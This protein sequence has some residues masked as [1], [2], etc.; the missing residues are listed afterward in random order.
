M[1]AAS[2]TPCEACE[3]AAKICDAIAADWPDLYYQNQ[4]WRMASEKIRQSCR[5]RSVAA[6]RVPVDPAPGDEGLVER[7][8]AAQANDAGLWFVAQTAPEAYLQSEL[9][10]LHA[11]VEA[12]ALARKGE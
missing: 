9:R 5:H 10:R 12:A 4:A 2:D 1:T 11:A 3:S 8:V 6:G 7:L